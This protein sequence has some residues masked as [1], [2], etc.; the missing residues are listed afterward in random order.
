MIVP[1][2]SGS[3]RVPNKNIKLLGNLPL[4]VHTLKVSVDCN[5]PTL[6]TTDSQEYIDVVKNYLGNQIE[7][8]LRPTAFAEDNTRVVEEVA[9]ICE[10]RGVS[11]NDTLGMM[12]PTSPFRTKETLEKAI[13]LNQ[14]HQKGVFTSAEYDFPVTF[15]F[16][17]C[18]SSDGQMDWNPIFGKNS[19]MIS[20]NTRSQNQIKTFHPTG[21]IYIF[22]YKDFSLEKSF[23]KNAL[24]LQIFGNEK[25]DIDNERDFQMA[26]AIIDKAEK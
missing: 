20:G 8:E 18:F 14:R 5:L 15:A 25:I 21:A 12:L 19:P 23:Y 16:E 17:E 10:D 3:K 1:A 2:R 4:V 24:P 6:F 13:E 22:K 7:Y 26:Q 9:R 11:P